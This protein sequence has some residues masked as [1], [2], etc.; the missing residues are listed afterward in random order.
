MPLIFNKDPLD[1]IRITRGNGLFSGTLINE[2][3]QL[4]WR[5]GPITPGWNATNEGS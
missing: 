1:Y 4:I 2:D 5:G 3:V